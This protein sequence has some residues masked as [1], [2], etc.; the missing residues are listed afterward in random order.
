MSRKRRASATARRPRATTSL[1]SSLKALV[2][3]LKSEDECLSAIQPH[4]HMLV[5]VSRPSAVLRLGEPIAAP[6]NRA[7]AFLDAFGD[8]LDPGV[9]AG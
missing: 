1:K 2:P 5:Q 3:G 8:T 7:P 4:Y 6:P 9:S